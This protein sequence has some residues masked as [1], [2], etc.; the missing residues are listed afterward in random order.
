[1]AYEDEINQ[2]LALSVIPL[3]DIKQ[4]SVINGKRSDFLMA[5]NLMNWFHDDFFSWVDQPECDTCHVKTTS[6]GKF[7]YFPFFL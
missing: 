4:K 2:T 3:E 1:M 6:T 5:K 7:V